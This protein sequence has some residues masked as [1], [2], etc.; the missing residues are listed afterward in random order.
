MA[1]SLKGF[2]EAVKKVDISAIEFH[3]R[4]GDF[5]SWAKHSL[6]DNELQNEF[7]NIRET[8][9]VGEELRNS[10]SKVT[11]KRFKKLSNYSKTALR[12]S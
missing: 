12:L 4:R 10:I 9:M 8:K 3:N 5:I 2:S 11:S 6:K 1:W 7:V